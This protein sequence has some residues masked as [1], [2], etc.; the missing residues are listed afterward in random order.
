MSGCWEW[1]N[2]IKNKRNRLVGGQWMILNSFK[3]ASQSIRWHRNL[4]MELEDRWQSQNRE[5]QIMDVVMGN[6]KVWRNRRTTWLLN[7]ACRAGDMATEGKRTNRE[8]TR[9][10]SRHINT[11]PIRATKEVKDRVNNNLLMRRTKFMSISRTHS[12][13]PSCMRIITW[14][15]WNKGSIKA[16]QRARREDQRTSTTPRRTREYTK[17]SGADSSSLG[18][19][20]SCDKAAGQ[21][22]RWRSTENLSSI[23]PKHHKA[24]TTSSSWNIKVAQKKTKFKKEALPWTNHSRASWTTSPQLLKRI[25]RDMWER[26]AGQRSHQDKLKC[27]ISIPRFN[28]KRSIS[29]RSF[30]NRG[31]HRRLTK[32]EQDSQAKSFHQLIGKKPQK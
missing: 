9:K 27:N 7:E 13:G 6:M 12:R 1:A 11:R 28:T 24:F 8:I 31:S 29:Q 26:A 5:R 25:R 32:E 3:I 30:S 4:N 10:R 14:R 17:V 23:S 20:M 22:C 2:R 19:T 21:R 18:S 15:I 16:S